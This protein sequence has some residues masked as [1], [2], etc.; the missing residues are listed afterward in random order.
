MKK[1]FTLI[2]LL[3]VIVILAIIALISVPMI[4]NVIEKA[5]KGALKDSAYGII[6]AANL[7]YSQSLESASNDITFTCDNEGCL[8]GENELSYKGAISGTG[9]II[10]FADG[11]TALCI[12][13]DKYSAIKNVEDTSVSVVQGSC[14][15]DEETNA[16]S[17]VATISQTTYDNMRQQ[18]EDQIAELTANQL[19]TS[20]ATATPEDILVGKTAYVNG[21]KLTGIGDIGVGTS[22]NKAGGIFSTATYSTVSFDLQIGKKYIFSVY[23]SNLYT[24]SANTVGTSCNY[25]P[26]TFTGADC[27]SV[28]T[29]TF[30]NDLAHNRACSGGVMYTYYCTATTTQ[31]TFSKLCV[32][33]NNYNYCQVIGN[34]YE[35]AF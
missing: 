7:Y 18:Y 31:I 13:G 14:E 35:L 32:N 34:G 4:M 6:E 20:D 33:D 28:G 25:N 8:S 12:N 24:Y 15:Y 26:V 9:S 17:T 10:L 21:I 2:E 5:K 1:G 16:Y 22:F 19:N 29:Q 27:T 3:A 30:L 23:G 11:K